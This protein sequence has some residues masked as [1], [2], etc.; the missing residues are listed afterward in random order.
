MLWRQKAAK[1]RR[2]TRWVRRGFFVI[3]FGPNG[4]CR[5]PRLTDGSRFCSRMILLMQ[6]KRNMNNNHSQNFI[7]ICLLLIVLL[8]LA[9]ST[10]T[11][12][13]HCIADTSIGSGIFENKNSGGH[14]D[15]AVGSDGQ[16]P[17]VRRG[18]FKFDISSIPSN[19]TIDSVTFEATV[20]KMPC[21]R[22][23]NHSKC[24]TVPFSDS[25]FDLYRLLKPWGEG[26]GTFK[27]GSTALAGEAT[28][29]SNQHSI[30][31]GNG[32]FQEAPPLQI[33]H[34]YLAPR[35]L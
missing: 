2:R 15:I 10:D 9:S 28:W 22:N 17:Y 25:T 31:N 16:I 8:P 32:L 13:A 21:A 24:L 26:V 35:P 34:L 30:A 6:K 3:P 5:K 11:L 29:N 20:V 4:S 23:A 1:K 27:K 19:S 14:Q 18:L 12:T 7:G 33:M